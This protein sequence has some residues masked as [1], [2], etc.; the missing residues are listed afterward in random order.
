MTQQD[1]ASCT[2]MS[3]SFINDKIRNR[4]KNGMWIVSA[5]KIATALDCTIDDLYEWIPDHKRGKSERI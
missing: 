2:G 4:G 1:L 5:K 3:K